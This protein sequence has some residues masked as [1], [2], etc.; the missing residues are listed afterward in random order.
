MLI[1]KGKKN[2]PNSHF[3]LYLHNKF[4]REVKSVLHIFKS[5]IFGASC[6]TLAHHGVATVGGSPGAL[7]DDFF[8]AFLV[9]RCIAFWV[10]HDRLK[11]TH[12]RR[13]RG[14]GGKSDLKCRLRHS[15]LHL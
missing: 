15:R 9:D 1:P 8:Q 6:R 5:G 4:N 7:A 11:K 14:G 3:Q 13:S 12:Q 2:P 10:T